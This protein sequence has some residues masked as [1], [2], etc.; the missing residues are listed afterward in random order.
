M[1]ISK[2]ELDA[3]V[4]EY[5][6]MKVIYEEAGAIVESI[7]S[8]LKEYMKENKLDEVIGSDYKLTLTEVNKQN[9]NT[10]LLNQLLGDHVDEYKTPSP[11][12][13]LGIR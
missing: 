12:Y 6:S 9:W 11:Y 8:E 4:A 13:K 7:K 10:K 3:K 2:D 5:R 1:S